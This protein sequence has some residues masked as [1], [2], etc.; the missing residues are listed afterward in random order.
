MYALRR[1]GLSVNR[2]AA[3]LNERGLPSPRVGRKGQRSYGDVLPPEMQSQWVELTAQ[4]QAS[5]PLNKT[6]V[7][8]LTATLMREQLAPNGFV[9]RRIGDDW[10]AQFFRPARDGYQ[11]VQMRVIGDT[12]FLRCVVRCGHR[13]EEVETVFE[14]IFG[15]AMRGQETFWFNPSIFVGSRSGGLPIENSEEIR[16]VLGVLER[17]GLPPLDL[18]REPGGLDR[19]MNDP[20][21][22]PFSYPNLHPQAPHNLADEYVSYGDNLCLKTLIV[23]WLARN[24]AFENRVDAL[25]KF[26]QQ[27]VD[28]SVSDLARVIDHLRAMPA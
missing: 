24:P 27:R 3:L 15:P 17:Y 12:P 4:A 18:A 10:D 25:R 2:I 26:V 6:E 7:T 5:P 20:Q 21:R 14:Q 1:S 16:G 28:V 22:F 8:Q 11:S 9:P 19:L 23:A 13:S